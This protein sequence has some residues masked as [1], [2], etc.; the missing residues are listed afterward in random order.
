MVAK[1]EL[2]VM[3]IVMRLAERQLAEVMAGG[4]GGA[5]KTDLTS[6]RMDIRHAPSPT[7]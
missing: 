4:G 5:S 7:H 2:A 1:M 3:R 6:S